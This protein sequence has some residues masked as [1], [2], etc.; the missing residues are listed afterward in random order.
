[1]PHKAPLRQV[2]MP[3]KAEA[4]AGHGGRP[5]RVV[6]GQD[7]GTAKPLIRLAT[8]NCPERDRFR[9]TLPGLSAV[10]RCRRIT[11]L[12]G[13]STASDATTTLFVQ[14]RKPGRRQDCY[15]SR[16]QTGEATNQRP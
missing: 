12:Y 5:A 4:F 8:A 2:G 7:F 16:P 10:G 1:M 13:K 15:S 3:R 14:Q 11:S 6:S 9:D